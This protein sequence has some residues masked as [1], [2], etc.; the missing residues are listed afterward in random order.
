MST[1]AYWITD[2]GKLIKPDSRHIITV[3]KNPT[4]FGETDKTIQNTFDKHGEPVNTNMEG[5]AREEVLLRV[6][7]RGNIRIRVNGTRNSQHWS[8]QLQ[9]LTPKIEDILWFWANTVIKNG[10]AKDKYADVV[11]H[12]L[13]KGDKMTRTSL[14]ILAK[15]GSIKEC[16]SPNGTLTSVDTHIYSDSDCNLLEDWND[17]VNI[18]DKYHLHESIIRDITIDELLLRHLRG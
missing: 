8:I 1:Y 4:K 10:V 14:D 6:I 13:G 7:R 9:K 2:K 18:I 12:E 5:K 15:G 11:I 16:V 17:Y 3:V